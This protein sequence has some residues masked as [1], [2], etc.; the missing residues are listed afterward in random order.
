MTNWKPSKCATKKNVCMVLIDS[1]L[2]IPSLRRAGSPK[3]LAEVADRI[4]SGEA[5]WCAA[6]RLELWAGVRDD[7]ERK[8]LGEFSAVVIDLPI[9]GEVW[10]KAIW[11]ADKGRRKGYTI[12]YPDLLIFA[13]AQAH[14]AELLHRD[15]HFQ[16]LAAL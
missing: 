15:Q 10:E 5:A 12:P 11:F 7:R 14:R 9:S 16:L 3:D 13:C 2:W 6:V 1:S 8:T 4:R